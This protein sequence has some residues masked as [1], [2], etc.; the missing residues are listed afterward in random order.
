MGDPLQIA[1]AFGILFLFF[2][3]FAVLS[4]LQEDKPARKSN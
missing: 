1:I 3:F 2:G 4:V